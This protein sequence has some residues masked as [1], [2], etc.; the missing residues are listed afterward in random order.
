LIGIGIAVLVVAIL[1]TAVIWRRKKEKKK[2]E[3]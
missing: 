1:G 2:T 3:E